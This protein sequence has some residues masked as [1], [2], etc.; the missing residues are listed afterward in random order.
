LS[1]G[2]FSWSRF[3]PTFPVAAASLSV[4]QP[5]HPAEPVKTALPAAALPDGTVV[6]VVEDVDDGAEVVPLTLWGEGDASSSPPHPATATP[7]ATSS[8]ASARDV[9]R[10]AAILSAAQAPPRSNR[11]DQTEAG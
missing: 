2:G 6:V 9:R 4:W 1:N 3:G 7:I 10:I 5:A 11:S 8:V